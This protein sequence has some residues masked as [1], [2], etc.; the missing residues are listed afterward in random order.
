MLISGSI[1]I[2]I[3]E[4]DNK[5][6]ILMADDHSNT[7]YCNNNGMENH[8]EIKNYLEDELKNN[9]QILLE[10]IPRDG[11]KLQELW[12]ES[13]HTQDLKNLF[14]DNKEI[15]G[16]DIR[17]YLVPFSW[18]VLEIDK[19]MINFL[20]VEYISKICDFFKLKGDFYNKLFHPLM[21]KVIVMNKGLGRNLNY[22]KKKFNAIKSKVIKDNKTIGYYFNNEKGFLMEFSNLCDEIMELYTI[23]NSLTTEKKSII[24]AGLFHA[25]N[26]LKWLIYS[27]DF[28]VIYKNGIIEYQP[29]LDSKN[30]SACIYLPGLN[31]FGFKD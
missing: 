10:E 29:K 20:M 14:L 23:L 25:H 15:T 13:P 16:I 21:K 1:G 19:K 11:F 6:I 2:T 4:K 26:M 30:V 27:Y 17:P 8:K 22:L 5:I 3:L 18:D 9:N 12:P 7:T 28:K 31:K 24:H